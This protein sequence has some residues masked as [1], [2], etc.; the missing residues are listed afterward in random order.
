MLERIQDAR[1]SVKSG[2]LRKASAG[3]AILPRR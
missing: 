3:L 2:A 1:G